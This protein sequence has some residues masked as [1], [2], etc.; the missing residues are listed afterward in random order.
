VFMGGSN[1]HSPAPV[2]EMTFVV[3]IVLHK[4]AMSH[5]VA[6]IALEAAIALFRYADVIIY[7]Q[8]LFA[9]MYIFVLPAYVYMY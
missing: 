9:C 6:S 8:S 2:I 4:G 3:S 7:I 5:I 1:P